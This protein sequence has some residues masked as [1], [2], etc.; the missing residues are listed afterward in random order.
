MMFSIVRYD[1]GIISASNNLSLDDVADLFNSMPVG[2]SSPLLLNVYMVDP[3]DEPVELYPSGTE[4][5]FFLC[6]ES[7]NVICSRHSERL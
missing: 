4:E 1:K 3:D 7:G 5:D 2:V 6:D